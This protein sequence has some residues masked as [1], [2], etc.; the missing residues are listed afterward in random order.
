LELS[1]A[2]FAAAFLVYL[3]RYAPILIGPRADGR[4]E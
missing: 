2:L 3:T 1:G 4:V